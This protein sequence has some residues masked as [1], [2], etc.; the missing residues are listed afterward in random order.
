MNQH[1]LRKARG[2]D[3]EALNVTKELQSDNRRLRLLAFGDS[4]HDGSMVGIHGGFGLF[5]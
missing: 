3:Q 5:S 4:N 2:T 1:G